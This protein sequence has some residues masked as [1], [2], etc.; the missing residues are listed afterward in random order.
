MNPVQLEELMAHAVRAARAASAAILEVWH[1]GDFEQEKKSDD[2]PLTRADRAAHQVIIDLLHPAGLPVL[3]EEGMDIPFEVRRMWSFFWM[4]D[5]LDGTKEFLNRNGDFTV[6]IALMEKNR[7]VAGVVAVPVEHKLY[8][9]GPAWGAWSM[10]QGSERMPLP[11]AER[12]ALHQPGIRVVASRSH[13]DERTEACIAALD[14]PILMSRGS[15]LKFMLL[16]EG[17][18]DFYPRFAPTMEWDT[19]AAQA[20]LEATGTGVRAEE[21]GEQLRYNKEDLRNPF[22]SCLAGNI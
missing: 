17:K 19:A 15:S 4:V 16:A 22:F 12:I 7:P 11:T 5:P 9:G 3:S 18:A 20:I 1:S 2:S 21:N 8:L 10:G 13:R 14:R 6:N